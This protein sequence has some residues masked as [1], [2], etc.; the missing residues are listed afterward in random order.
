MGSTFEFERLQKTGEVCPVCGHKDWCTRMRPHDNPSAVMYMCQ[1]GASKGFPLS[2]MDTFFSSYHGKDY[3]VLS[4]KNTI[5]LEEK[6]EWMQFNPGRKLKDGTVAPGSSSSF[7]PKPM[8]YEEMT[9]LLPPDALD[10]RYRAFLSKLVLEDKHRKYLYSEGFTDAMIEK[11]N[12]RS[13]PEPD[14]YRYASRSYK[15]A[16]HSRKQIMGQMEKQFGA[17]LAGTPGFFMRDNGAWSFNGP[18]GIVIPVPD[19]N[20]RYIGMRIRTDRRWFDAKGNTITKEQYEK[21]KQEAEKKGVPCSSREMGKY[22]WM[23]SYKGDSKK[24]MNNIIANAYKFG[25]SSG[26]PLG[27]YYPATTDRNYDNEVVFITEGEKKSIVAS[28]YLGK[29]CID[30]PGVN[31]WRQLF[32][33]DKQGVRPVDILKESGV[34]LC[35]VAYDADKETNR[36]VLLQQDKLVERLKNEGILV[37][38]ANWDINGGTTKGLDDLLVKG[39]RPEYE[40]ML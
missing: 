34:K 26:C 30:I 40:L 29:M 25:V 27:Y 12:I 17:K 16:N 36:Q 5:V 21:D 22:V 20:G 14:G 15:S 1:R 39:G 19:I 38:I 33:T 7:K 10:E 32:E 13:I 37:A 11:Y 6:N 9:P 4:C 24:A 2:P 31:N 8:V 23:S 35:V 3:V 18:G 28:E